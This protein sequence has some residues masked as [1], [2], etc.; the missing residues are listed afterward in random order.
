MELS[1]TST[2]QSSCP[3]VG[4]GSIGVLGG[5]EGLLAHPKVFMDRG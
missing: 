5:K 4:L 3:W 1:D 2:Q